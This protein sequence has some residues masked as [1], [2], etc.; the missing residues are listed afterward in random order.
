MNNIDL[1]EPKSFYL[2]INGCKYEVKLLFGA[3]D[4]I[5]LEKIEI[6]DLDTCRNYLKTVILRHV[7]CS[8]QLDASLITDECCLE[9]INAFL[10]ADSFVNSFYLQIEDDLHPIKRFLCAQEE[11]YKDM[12]SS[13]ASSFERL[14]TMAET[15]ID[16]LKPAIENVIECSRVLYESILPSIYNISNIFV[17]A[18]KQ[19][20]IPELSEDEKEELVEQYSLWG[21]FGWT[22]TSFLNKELLDELPIDL[23]DANK[24]AKTILNKEGVDELFLQ[25]HKLSTIRKS[26]LEELENCYRN[27]CYKACAMI[28]FSMI[29]SKLF[30]IQGKSKDRTANKG[31]G[32]LK[33]KTDTESIQSFYNYLS[34]INLIRSLKAMYKFANNFEKQ[35]D[36]INRNFVDHGM[37]HKNVGQGDAIKT[38]L[39]TYNLYCLLEE[40]VL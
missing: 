10:E 29:D 17:E 6:D 40:S 39:A 36:V 14:S 3:I 33:P 30:R 16:N 27:K 2:N 7:S 19:L 38:I 11:A 31:I 9:Y 35:F 1:P 24:K 21:D 26:D 32:E 37:L 28:S 25:M 23:K 12:F 4:F 5:D 34:A 18:I 20:S 15:I 13:D 8:E 22:S